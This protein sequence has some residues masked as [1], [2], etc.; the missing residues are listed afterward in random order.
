M[1]TLVWCGV[2]GSKHKVTVNGGRVMGPH[3]RARHPGSW[4]PPS[5]E[6]P[7]VSLLLARVPAQQQAGHRRRGSKP[8]FHILLVSLLCH[9]F[10]FSPI[11]PPPSFQKGWF[12]SESLKHICIPKTSSGINSSRCRGLFFFFPFFFPPYPPS[13]PSFSFSLQ[14]QNEF[15]ENLCN[16]GTVVL[17]NAGLQGI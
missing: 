11:F 17:R 7:S 14:T 5:M 1:A 12:S 4:V 6:H 9:T 15:S 16:S 8:S 3:Q 10:F 13:F 2:V